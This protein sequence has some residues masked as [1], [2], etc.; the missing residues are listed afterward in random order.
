MNSTKK[1]IP[2]S[3]NIDVH[4][5]LSLSIYI[6][7]TS[8]RAASTDLPDPLSPPVSIVQLRES[9][10]SSHTE[11]LWYNETVC[12]WMTI[13]KLPQLHGVELSIKR[14]NS[15]QSFKARLFEWIELLVAIKW[16]YVN[17]TKVIHMCLKSLHLHQFLWGC[18]VES[19]AD[20]WVSQVLIPA[21][22]ILCLTTLKSCDTT[23]QSVCGW[24]Y[25]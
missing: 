15:C 16:A 25:I 12:L 13:Y 3:F 14:I 6:Y 2:I 19:M 21:S 7:S 5:P 18:V 10:V 20:I 22:R 9:W 24:I 1:N 23:K 8:C 17:K 11:E 4:L